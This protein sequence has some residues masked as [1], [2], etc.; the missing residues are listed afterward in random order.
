M[1]TPTQGISLEVIEAQ[2]RSNAFFLGQPE[3]A[4]VAG[5]P[6]VPNPFGQQHAYPAG[7][8]L[9]VP[10]KSNS[11]MNKSFQS[12]SLVPAAAPEKK[13]DEATAAMLTR[14]LKKA[15]EKI[16]ELLQTRTADRKVSLAAFIVRAWVAGTIAASAKPRLAAD[17][18]VRAQLQLAGVDM[19]GYGRG[20]RKRSVSS[21]RGRGRGNSSKASN[22]RHRHHH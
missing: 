15:P 11:T 9:T 8:R 12:T 7:V 14:W 13:N 21:S 3:V 6:D 20:K 22:K 16:L 17:P 2:S 19:A 5:T 1:T 4:S 18:N 10:S